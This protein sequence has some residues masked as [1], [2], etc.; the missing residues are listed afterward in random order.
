MRAEIIATGSELLTGRTVDTNSLF[1]ADGLLD[2]GI[3]TAFKSV[4]GD[5]EKDME[6]VFRRAL[7]RAEVIVIT[8]GLGPTEDD[9]TR[10]VLAR[11][12]KKRLVLNEKALKAIKDVFAARNR[13]YPASNDRQA[14]I[15]SGGRVLANPVGIAPGFFLIEEG[16]FIAVLPGVPQEMRTMF[17]ESLRHEL[18]A[19]CRSEVFIHRKVLHTWGIAESKVNEQL[20]DILKKGKPVMG[21]TARET[22]VD[23]SILAKEGSRDRALT[24]ADRTETEVRKRLGDAVYGMDSQ[25]MEEVVGALLRHRKL[26]LSAAESCTGGLISSRITNTPGSSD[27]FERAVVTYSNASKTELLGVPAELIAAHGAVSR[28]VAAAMATGI[29]ERAKTSLGIAITGI[30]GPGGG[31][32]EKPVGLVYLA[33]ATAEGV[34]VEERRF[35]G[36]RDQIRQRTAQAALDMVRRHLI[37]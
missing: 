31:T 3:E 13:E 11:M 28:E 2:L 10:K 7:D 20:E 19:H 1:L 34:S 18:A 27:Y 37:A 12:L 5:D 36:D 35:L 14:L 6:E 23:I 30:A 4:V 8:G 15:P 9:I 17:S 22:G 33:L 32:A 16:R 24:L 25:A 29:R 26:T 21:L